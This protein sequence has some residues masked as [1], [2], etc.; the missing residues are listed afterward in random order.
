MKT[1]SV[2]SRTVSDKPQLDEYATTHDVPKHRSFILGLSTKQERI[3]LRVFSATVRGLIHKYGFDWLL[4]NAHNALSK[5]FIV[6][7]L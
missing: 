4:H 2:T 6:Q 1:S 7:A 5:R 3:K